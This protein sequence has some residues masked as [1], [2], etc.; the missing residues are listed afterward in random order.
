[1]TDKAR[2]HIIVIGAGLLG[3]C[4]ALELARAGK[5]VTL[6]EKALRPM[7]RASSAGEGKL[8]LGL[9]YANDPSLKTAEV[10]MD[11]ALSFSRILTRLLGNHWKPVYSSPFVYAVAQDSLLDAQTLETFY[12]ELEKRFLNRLK[13]RDACYLG[14]RPTNLFRRL[15]PSEFPAHLNRDCFQALFQ[16]SELALAPEM[17]AESTRAALLSQPRIELHSGVRVRSVSE[18]QSGYLVEAEQAGQRL[19]FQADQI[20]NC[21]W[22]RR[23]AIDQTMG[24]THPGSWLHRLKY[25]LNVLLPPALKNGPSVT[26]VL[27]RYGD[28]VNRGNLQGYLSWYPSGLRGW[29][30]AIEPPEHWDLITG[31]TPPLEESRE[32]I[33]QT[34]SSINAW[35]PS[36]E[37]ARIQNIKAGTIVAQGTSDVNDPASG[38]HDRAMASITSVKGY[39]SIYQGKLTTS[40]YF[41]NLLAQKIIGKSSDA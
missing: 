25:S 38:L 5:R 14:T 2:E 10:M 23:M 30:N 29:S 3:S 33:H 12:T 15:R 34:L 24:I 35:Y 32:V 18:H 8:H 26:M 20:I 9:V 31:D 11:G 36:M 40:P 6:L 39:H 17:L 28:V 27:G 16:T 37:Q 7:K 13:D 22:E 21:S 1:M 4:M 19:N 41:A